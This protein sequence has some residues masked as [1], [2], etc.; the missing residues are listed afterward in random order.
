MKRVKINQV[1]QG[2]FFTLRDYSHL[3]EIPLN[4]VWVRN[5][6]DRATKSFSASKAEDMNHETFLKS[7]RLVWID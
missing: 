4:V 6:Y 5:H 1:K 2:D 7:G 3:E